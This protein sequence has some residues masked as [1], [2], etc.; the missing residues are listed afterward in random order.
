MAFKKNDELNEYEL[1]AS[2][3]ASNDK[4]PS[5]VGVPPGDDLGMILA[6]GTQILAGVDQVVVGRHCRND[7][8]PTAIGRKAVLR[9]LSDVAAM[10][11]RPLA[12]LAAATLPQGLGASWGKELHESLR[13]TAARF[14]APLI[15]GDLAM[16]AGRDLPAVLSVTVLAEPAL[17]G[18]K[19]V[20]RS[21]A[22][23]GDY[24]A[25]TGELGGSLEQ[26]GGGRHLD[27]KPRIAEAI[28]L[29]ELLGDGLGAMLDVSDG[30]ASDLNRIIE[31][32]LVPIRCVLD[33]ALIP[34]QTGCTWQQAVGDGEDYELLFCSREVPPESIEGVPV[35]IIGRVH[36][37]AKG[38]PGVVAMEDGR[39]IDLTGFGWEH[40]TGR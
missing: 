20:L 6:S 10:A 3:R 33:T 9:A 16:H 12:T 22:R 26:D 14:D 23:P 19:V 2:I 36:E 35:S 4:L 15:G 28:A 29:A 17:P 18:D 24:I 13:A 11:A 31:S 25:V 38:G 1:H 21:G 39:A 8:S 32:A 40:A 5:R 37:A 7:E 30:V 34:A 27:F